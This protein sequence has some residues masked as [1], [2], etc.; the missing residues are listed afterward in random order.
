MGCALRPLLRL[1]AAGGVGRGRGPGVES[2]RRRGAVTA[3]PDIVFPTRDDPT[4]RA[5]CEG[6]GGPA[7]RRVAAA[8]GWWN[9]LR[10][11]LALAAFTMAL[12]VVERE[13]CHAHAWSRSDGQQYAHAC[14]SDIPQLYRER[15]FADGARPYLDPNNYQPLEYPVL[16]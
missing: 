9:P 4:L 8:R 16:T 1:L 15:G 2:G 5:G 12:G 3:S 6:V 11:L 13:P 7:G 14:Y 10:V